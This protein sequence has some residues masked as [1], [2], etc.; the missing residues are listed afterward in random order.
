M[1]TH[2]TT[3][4]CTQFENRESRSVIDIERC[5][6]QIID[7]FVQTIP[8]IRRQLSI[9]D[10]GTLDLTRIRDQAVH[11]L[12]IRHLQREESQR[13]AVISS[14]V[15]SHRQGEGG[16]THCRTSRHNHKVA[17][18]P[19]GG[20]VVEL[21]IARAHTREAVF[22]GSSCLD[23]LNG[24]RDDGINLRVILLH[25]P[26]T[27]LKE[28]VFSLLHQFVDVVGLIKGLRL[29]DAGE[30]DELTGQELLGDDVGVILDIGGG[31]HTGTEVGHITRTS[32]FL[33]LAI[34]R[35]TLGNRQDIYGFLLDREIADGGVDHLVAG[36]IETLGIKDFAD[37]GVGVL[38]NHQGSQH[39]LLHLQ[40]LGLKMTVGVVYRLL[41]AR[42]ATC[43]VILFCHFCLGL[44]CK[45]TKKK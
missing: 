34:L 36:L 28:R 17:G 10:L 12:H 30:G 32:H 5:I 7:A 29:D 24:L 26:L 18:L 42:S 19:S 25:I 23:A 44:G 20:D 41:F 43:V 11:Q 14:D 2:Q 45:D 6:Q 40:R 27:Q 1:F 35:Q 9:Q 3:C 31:C 33:Q 21:V 16:L 38:I 8:F 37:D 39:S 4:L 13:N 15:L 22:V